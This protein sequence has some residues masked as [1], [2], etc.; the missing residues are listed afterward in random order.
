M[1][2][3]FIKMMNGWKIHRFIMNALRDRHGIATAAGG[4]N[5]FA[6]VI[7][8]RFDREDP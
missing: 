8:T 1:E 2:Y 5:R 4:K 3:A 7:L 6:R